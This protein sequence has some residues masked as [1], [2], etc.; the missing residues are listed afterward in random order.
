MHTSCNV[1]PDLI[2]ENDEIKIMKKL[3]G[4]I[5]LGGIGMLGVIL[6]A[7]M[8]TTFEERV[9]YCCDQGKG[10]HKTFWLTSS[11]KKCQVNR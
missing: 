5:R 11:P 8:W 1:I 3:E 9:H 4:L 7:N 2:I 6:Y 10:K